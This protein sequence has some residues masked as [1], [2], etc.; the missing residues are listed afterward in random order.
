M[1]T[2]QAVGTRFVRGFGHRSAGSAARPKPL[3]R[4]APSQPFGSTSH[5]PTREAYRRVC[6]ST[7]VLLLAPH[8]VQLV[9]MR[10][11]TGTSNDSLASDDQGRTWHT[12]N[13]YSTWP[14]VYYQD[15]VRQG[16]ELLAFGLTSSDAFSGT[17]LW[18]SNDQ[19]STWTGGASIAPA[20][21]WVTMINR[22]SLTSSGRVI[23]PVDQMLGGEGSGPDNVGTIY[24]DN[25]GQSWQ[26]SPFFGP[27]PGYPTAPEGIGEPAVVELA[28]GKTWMVCRGL[29]GHLWQSFSDDDGATWG[30]PSP[31]TLVSPLS[32]VNAKRIPG[33]NAVIAIW[34]NATPGT[35]TTLASTASGIRARPWST[36]SAKTTARPGASRS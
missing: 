2:W 13:A 31:T 32:A 10:G 29:G 16:N 21:N 5:R 35:S 20:D 4:T 28:N 14:H 9:M 34:D 27:P 25:A 12:W 22:V 17:H 7:P 23:V 6:G 1:K 33:T 18:Q 8:K 30:T 11:N 19:G 26:Q 15:V 24:S 36:P 3:H